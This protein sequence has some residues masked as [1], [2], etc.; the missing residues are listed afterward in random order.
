MV[1]TIANT[2]R[3]NTIMSPSDPQD[4]LP[5]SPTEIHNISVY[6]LCITFCPL[7]PIPFVDFFLEPWLA[8]KMLQP[9]VKDFSQ[10]KLFTDTRGIS[11]MGCL[12]ATILWPILKL[13]TT[14]RFFLQFKTYL[15]SFQY[16]F[17]KAYIVHKSMQIHS[18]ILQKEGNMKKFA[19]DVD[20]FLQQDN[21]FSIF[22]KHCGTWI[23]NSPLRS[24][25]HMFRSL[26]PE[27]PNISTPTHNVFLN[28]LENT[29]FI[30]QWMDETLA[31]YS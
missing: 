29:E 16:W 22:T 28:L 27:N 31:K 12:G 1:Y 13:I 23:Q 2:F 11:C 9:F 8:G 6:C 3:K 26:P 10:R 5:L 25:Q 4:T 7:I 24:I 20:N 30:D 19:I 15:R 21:T 18:N 17:Y 14:L